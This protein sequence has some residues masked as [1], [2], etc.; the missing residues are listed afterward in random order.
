MLPG[1]FKVFSEVLGVPI[2]TISDETSPENTPQWDSFQA[3][4]LVIALEA[5]F[6]VRFSTKEIV[7]MRTVGLVRKVLANK[8]ISD[9]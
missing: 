5:A 1:V 4:N 9:V 7:S 3:M 2:E 8:G 6:D